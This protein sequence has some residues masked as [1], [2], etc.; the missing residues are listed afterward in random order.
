MFTIHDSTVKE[1]YFNFTLVISTKTGKIA[2]GHS[3]EKVS[4]GHV[5]NSCL[6]I[7]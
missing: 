5:R 6:V 3:S 4:E 1:E 7:K 2:P